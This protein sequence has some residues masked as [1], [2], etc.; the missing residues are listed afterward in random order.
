MKVIGGL[1]LRDSRQQVTTQMFRSMTHAVS[2]T[3]DPLAIGKGAVGVFT[4]GGPQSLESDDCVL[5]TEDLE[6]TNVEE[7]AA[8]TGLPGTFQGLLGALYSQEGWKFIDRLQGGFAF[9]LWDKRKRQLLLAVDRFG[10]KRL[11]YTIDPSRFAFA[12]RPSALLGLEGVT[13]SADPTAV[14]HYLNFGFLP[15]PMSIFS[16]LRRLPPG[17]LLI[18]R[19]G[20]ITVETYWDLSYP[21]QPIR[22]SEASAMAAQAVEEAVKRTLWGISPKET[23]AFLSGG[24][25]SST[26]VG[27]MTKTS[28]REINAFSIGFKEEPFNEL[29]YA[30][31]AARHFGAAHYQKIVTPDDA[32]ETIPLLVEAYD[33]PYGNNAIIPTYCCV[34]LARECGMTLLVAGDGGDEIFGGNERYRTDRIFARY[35]LVPA[36][37]RHHLV[38]PLLGA[39]PDGGG[40]IVGKAQRYVR[41]ANVPNPLRVYSYEFFAKQEASWLLAPEFL[42]TASIEAPDQVLRAHYDRANA[43]SELNRLLYLDMKLTI[44]DND[45]LKVT[46]TAELAGLAVRFPML[47]ER[48]VELTGRLPA[49]YKV[50]GLEKRYLFKRAFAQLLPKEILRKPKHGFGVPVSLWLKSHKKFRELFH[51]TLLSASAWTRDYFEPNAMPELFRLHAN[52][53][54][55]YYGDQLWTFL[56]LELWQRHHLSA[57]AGI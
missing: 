28:G 6:L 52:D 26:L 7:L 57:R 8:L 30:E 20:Q 27:L 34:K 49:H 38:E 53:P 2:P 56:M 47:D 40:S 43:T 51:D 9:A 29:K 17:H 15:S 36:A 11:Y 54:T 45:L 22:V 48:L 35:H 39:L 24:T 21:E 10:I 16:G 32:F 33:E 1:A 55:P 25:D 19:D 14:F 12:S 37:I 41:R 42:R 13:R 44:G 31:V 3:L 4:T 50:K 23:G 46:R 18:W 5:I